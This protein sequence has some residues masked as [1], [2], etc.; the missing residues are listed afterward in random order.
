MIFLSLTQKIMQLH[1]PKFWLLSRLLPLRKWAGVFAFLIVIGHACA[2]FAKEG[3]FGD[4]QGMIDV[5]FSTHHAAVFG[6]IA[7]LIML[8]LFLTS[9]SWAVKTMGYKSWKNLQRFA[10]L[11]FVFTAVH[12]ALLEYFGRGRIDWEPIGWLLAYC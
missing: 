2:T 8:P 1:F 3:V 6:S 11:A 4:I 9:T 7:F 5:S 10:H 12:V